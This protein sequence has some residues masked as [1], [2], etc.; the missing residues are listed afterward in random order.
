VGL[1]DRWE[2][3]YLMNWRMFDATRNSVA[4]RAPILT[5]GGI[6]LIAISQTVWGKSPPT[7]YPGTE[8]YAAE[9]K[10]DYP[11]IYAQREALLA[12]SHGSYDP[13]IAEQLNALVAEPQR[14][15]ETVVDDALALEML[16]ANLEAVRLAESH[17]P[18]AC[19]DLLHGIK[20]EGEL[21]THNADRN[22][23]LMA[24]ALHNA[25]VE[26]HRDLPLL[27]NAEMWSILKSVA[28]QSPDDDRLVTEMVR[29]HRPPATEAE[30]AANCRTGILSLEETISRGPEIAGKFVRFDAVRRAGRLPSPPATAPER[31]T[32]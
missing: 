6:V 14:A 23:G 5:L 12:K 19:Y 22:M 27:S 28:L 10:R 20:R 1:A 18:R 21:D 7:Q 31:E 17:S 8:A 25:V 16:E 9:L 30:L 4:T 15:A 26:P 11:A 32:H 24:R 13:A 2:G 29:A 3:R